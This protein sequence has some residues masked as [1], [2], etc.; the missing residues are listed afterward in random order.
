MRERLFFASEWLFVD[1]TIELRFEFLSIDLYYALQVSFEKIYCS[2]AL[3]PEK[4]F[5]T[6]LK[7]KTFAFAQK[8][9]EHPESWEILRVPRSK[10]LT[11]SATL[12]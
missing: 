6:K 10:I 11:V 3:E 8:W 7:E 5:R 9:L 12:G 2:F 1:I 4:L